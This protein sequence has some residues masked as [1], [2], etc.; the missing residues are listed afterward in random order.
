MKKQLTGIIRI[1]EPILSASLI[2]FKTALDF[3]LKTLRKDLIEKFKEQNGGRIV[4]YYS[5]GKKPI[6]YHTN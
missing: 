5:R 3:Q 2:E 1:E 4:R 6:T